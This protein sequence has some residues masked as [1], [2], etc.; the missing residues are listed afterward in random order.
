VAGQ[1]SDHRPGDFSTNGSIASQQE[2]IAPG[3]EALEDDETLADRDQTLADADQTG[4][5]DDQ[6]ASDSDQAAAD[7]D[8]EASD[9]DL[10]DGGDPG[11]HDIT[12]DIRD[13]SAEK[14]Q[15]SSQQRVD[16]GAARDAVAQARDRTALARDKAAALRDRELTASARAEAAAQRDRD[17]AAREADLA[18][19]GQAATG[20]EIAQRAEENHK[21][22]GADRAAA[23]ESRARAAL[24][25]EQAALDR[26]QAARDRLQARSERDALL[27]QLA[28]AETDPLTGACTRAPGL[29]DLDHEIDRARRATSLLALAYVDVVGLKAENDTHGHSA[30]D[31]LLQRVVRAIRGHLRSYDMIVRIGGNEFVCVMSAATLE[32]A[33]Q[34]FDAVRAALAGDPDP[35]EIK[36]GFAALTP[37]DSAAELIERAD[38]DL[39]NR[40]AD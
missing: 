38:A 30:G 6:T 32:D 39:P 25:R 3:S 13:R 36:V 18:D 26:E 37:E 22:A 9:R 29:A 23:V 7:C 14:R 12:R 10:V 1:P 40:R 19:G 31:A 34:R 11:T 27:D 17:L 21:R 16:K 15:Q 8:Q 5:D 28:I 33:R 20:A 2:S 35:C 24:A 4:S